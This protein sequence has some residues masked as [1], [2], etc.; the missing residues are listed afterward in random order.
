MFEIKDVRRCNFYL[1]SNPEVMVCELKAIGIVCDEPMKTSHGYSIRLQ[2]IPDGWKAYGEE[3]QNFIVDDQHNFLIRDKWL[4]LRFLSESYNDEYPPKAHVY[5]CFSANLLNGRFGVMC[6]DYSHFGNLLD[7]AAMGLISIADDINHLP[8][9]ESILG[10]AGC[11]I[12]Q[13]YYELSPGNQAKVDEIL[14]NASARILCKH[15]PDADKPE[16]YWGKDCTLQLFRIMSDLMAFRHELRQSKYIQILLW[17]QNM[18]RA[19]WR[20][21]PPSL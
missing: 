8:G 19:S 7:P 12:M 15:L 6:G 21:H 18:P 10:P 5:R 11:E 2:K 9:A 20:N 17:R 4:S 13:A 1:Y 14:E 3:S 16:A